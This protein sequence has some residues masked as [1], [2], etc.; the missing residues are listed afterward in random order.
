MKAESREKLDLARDILLAVALAGGVIALMAVAP[1]LTILLKPFAKNYHR[2]TLETNHLRRRL[3]KLEKSG[4]LAISERDG[5]TQLR[6]TKMGKQK[7]LEYQVDEMTIPKQEPW[8][9]MY[10]FVMFDVPETKR[11]RRD[12]FRRKLVELGFQKIQQSVWRHRYPCCD[13]VEFLTNLYQIAEYVDIVEG[14]QKL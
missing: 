7:I 13:Q 8:D 12:V 3:D 4:L 2:R 9:G 6:L 10:R 5:K 1:G 14:K 11:L